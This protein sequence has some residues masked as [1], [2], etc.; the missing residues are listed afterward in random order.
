MRRLELDPPLELELLWD[1]DDELFDDELELLL[2]EDEDELEPVLED[3]LLCDEEL[4]L[5]LLTPLDELE[6]DSPAELELGE[7]GSGPATV[8]LPQPA[9]SR[10]PPVSSKRNSR[11]AAIAPSAS[12]PTRP[13]LR[14]RPAM[15][16]PVLPRKMGRRVGGR[17]PSPDASGA[18]SLSARRMAQ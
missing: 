17:H 7:A 5:E 11:R 1:D 16:P 6:L 8:E 3:E 9:T 14:S 12:A 4:L 10:A 18:I 13:T 15:P 2:E